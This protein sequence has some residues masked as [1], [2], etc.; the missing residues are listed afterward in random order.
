LDEIPLINKKTTNKPEFRSSDF[1]KV[2]RDFAF[3]LDKSVKGSDLIDTATKVDR[4][5][6]QNVEI[7][8][9]FEDSNLGDNNKSMAIKVVMQASDRT[10]NENEIQ[11]LSS[12][13]VGAI[14]KAT[15]GSVRS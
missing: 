14:E 11:E 8:D 6:I 1:Q 10:L 15:S 7:F 9:L 13:I 12:K 3:I 2:S 4:N 5:I